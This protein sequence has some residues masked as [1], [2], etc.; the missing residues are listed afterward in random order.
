MTHNMTMTMYDLDYRYMS[1]L[2][3]GCTRSITVELLHE[4]GFLIDTSSKIQ[5]IHSI[6]LA[7]C[8]RC[9]I[10]KNERGPL[11]SITTDD[12]AHRF[13]HL[14]RHLHDVIDKDMPA[15]VLQDKNVGYRVV[16][17]FAFLQQIKTKYELMSVIGNEIKEPHIDFFRKGFSPRLH[18]LEDLRRRY[19][20]A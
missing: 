3:V 8:M 2:C 11:K 9:C 6:M 1:F 5:N 7:L 10:A 18:E 15:L 17:P 12:Y 19:G 16:F 13:A 4:K 14:V 20:K